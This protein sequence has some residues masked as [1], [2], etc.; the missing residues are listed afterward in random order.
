MSKSKKKSGYKVGRPLNSSRTNNLGNYNKD[1]I[2]SLS[3]A[4]YCSFST[5]SNQTFLSMDSTYSS[6]NSTSS[7]R[8]NTGKWQTLQVAVSPLCSNNKKKRKHGN[9][10]KSNIELSTVT[11]QLFSDNQQTKSIG[12]RMIPI[13]QLTDGIKNNLTCVKCSSSDSTLAAKELFQ[14]IAN[15]FFPHDKEKKKTTQSV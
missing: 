11:G 15:E 3:L 9:I 7:S 10:S 4:S 2:K 12:N 6:A 13:Q 5:P 8:D 14:D 1:R